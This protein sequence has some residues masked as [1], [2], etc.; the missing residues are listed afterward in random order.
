MIQCLSIRRSQILILWI[1][2]LCL[3]IGS[4]VYAVSEAGALFLL[5]SPSVQAAGMGQTYGALAY[6]DPMAA[7]FNPAFLGFYTSQ[8]KAGFASSGG[9]WLEALVDDMHYSCYSLAYR[10]PLKNS[11]VS[12]GLGLHHV[13]LDLG[14]QFN[15]ANS[16]D[17]LDTFERKDKAYLVS[18][19]VFWDSYVQVGV[20]MNFKYIKSDYGEV[21]AS[22]YAVDFGLALEM[23]LFKIISKGSKNPMRIGSGVSPYLVPGLS[24]SAENIGGKLEYIDP[25]QADP[26][27]RIAYAGIHLRTG[28]QVES[29]N[30]RFDLISFSWAREA[31][32]M[33]VTRS[34]DSNTGDTQIDYQ[35][36][37]DDIDPFE[38]L[39]MGKGDEKV[40]TK[41]GWMVGIW[42]VY[43]ARWGHYVD[44]EGKVRYKTS[45]WGFNIT[46]TIRLLMSYSGHTLGDDAFGKILQNL[47]IEIQQSEINAEPGHPL[48]ETVFTGVTIRLHGN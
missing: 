12:I 4:S 17:P 23:P 43:F 6:T 29:N 9:D 3:C 7:V 41:K 8:Y 21:D 39:L 37:L 48:D 20:G 42:D 24:Y 5:I 36:G 33:L 13:F 18:A 11:P 30:N 10:L 2:V 14:E 22:A 15:T 32:D 27:P 38:H 16:P 47:D 26:I 46:K 44:M 19:S 1:A 35:W 40:I 34:Y 31:T 28:L 25:D 45:G